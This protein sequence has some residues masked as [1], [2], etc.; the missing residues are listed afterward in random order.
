MAP[1][2]ERQQQLLGRAIAALREGRAR[3]SRQAA[4][5]AV[6]L[7]ADN[8]SIWGV[9]AMACRDLG[10]LPGAQTA[11]ERSI[12]HEPRNPRAF[13]VKGDVYHASGNARAAAAFYR[14]AL[15][16]AA[17]ENSPA[18]MREELQRAQTRVAAFQ[19]DF[20]R[21]LDKTIEAFVAT[22]E[23]DTR[24][25]REALDILCG[26][27][28]VYH[29]QPRHFLFPGLTA[30]GFY[31]A[32]AFSWVRALEASAA[33]IRSELDA[34]LERNTPFSPYLTASADRPAYDNH[35][36]ADN[37]DW[38][39]FY[40]WR[41]GKALADNQA[42]CPKTTAAIKRV[43]LVFSGK[44]CP[45]VLFSRLKAGARIPAHT[46]MI[47]TRLIAHL[48]LIVPEGC[49]FRVGNDS[50]PWAQG[51]VWLFDD[52]IE[53]EAWNRSDAERIILIFEVW[54]PELSEAERAFV[55]RIL[56]A[57]DDY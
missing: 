42:L 14:D 25:M 33:D 4:A 21:Y 47:N 34:L 50:R 40:L 16:F 57:V 23:A 29:Q 53:H 18:E 15:K 38:G 11:A 26:R 41:D 35:G 20:E 32:S 51:K 5:Q 27:R 55:S 17:P 52:T 1:P 36:M 28:Q 6:A 43:P 54:K 13:V 7:G 48:A 56:Q 31:E 10:D 49:G 44:R 19:R 9:L 22:C 46:G 12:A 45:S 24:R 2:P 3:E 30:K 37:S 39:A 8:A